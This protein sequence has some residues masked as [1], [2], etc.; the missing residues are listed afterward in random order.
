MEVLESHSWL[1]RIRTCLQDF[2]RRLTR[3]DFL[4]I[5]STPAPPTCACTTTINI[6][7]VGVEN[8]EKFGARCLGMLCSHRSYFAS[9]NCYLSP[10]KTLPAV[11]IPPRV[12]LKWRFPDE[13][14][15]IIF[16]GSRRCLAEWK[17]MRAASIKLPFFTQKLFPS[18]T[19]TTSSCCRAKVPLRVCS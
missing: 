6:A 18:S 9:E 13:R 4:I 8:A 10:D 11:K 2:L 15:G 16:K 12:G 17:F 7:R 3:E 1:G 19:P 14:S 5:N